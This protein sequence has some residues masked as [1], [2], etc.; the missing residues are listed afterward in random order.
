MANPTITSATLT[1]NFIDVVFSEAVYTSTGASGALTTADFTLTYTDNADTGSSAASLAAVTKTTNAALSG[2]ETSIRMHITTTG[3]PMGLA[4]IEVKPASSTAIYNATDE[5]MAD[6]ETTGVKTLNSFLH[7]YVCKGGASGNSGLIASLPKLTLVQGYGITATGQNKILVCNGIFEE[8]PIMDTA[9]KIVSIVADINNLWSPSQTAIDMNNTAISYCPNTAVTGKKIAMDSN[10]VI[11]TAYND[12]GKS[13]AVNKSTDYGMSWINIKAPTGL[14][15]SSSDL[16][17]QPSI[18][19]D[20]SDNLHMVWH[21]NTVAKMFYAKYTSSTNTWSAV[22]QIASANTSNTQYTPDIALDSSGYPHIVWSGYDT[23]YTTKYQIKYTKWTGSAWTNWVN[24][25][26]V[27]GYDQT[28]P[29]IVIGANNYPLVTWKGTDATYTTITQIKYSYYNGT[30]WSAAAN[31]AAAATYNQQRP[32]I[33]Y[34]ASKVYLCWNAM[35]ATQTT[36]DQA[37]FCKSSDEGATWGSPVIIQA[38]AYNH[39]GVELAFATNNDIWCVSPN[40]NGTLVKTSTSTDDGTTWGAWTSTGTP[41]NGT[42]YHSNISVCSTFEAFIRPVFIILGDTAYMRLSG[43]WTQTVTGGAYILSSINAP[44]FGSVLL[45]E[46]IHHRM[47]IPSTGVN[48]G[49]VGKNTANNTITIKNSKINSLNTHRFCNAMTYVTTTVPITINFDNCTLYNNDASGAM[50]LCDSDTNYAQLN[51]TINDCDFSTYVVG[52]GFLTR[53]APPLTPTEG[54][55]NR[56]ITISGTTKIRH[57]DQLYSIMIPGHNNQLIVNDATFDILGSS[58]TAYGY[59]SAANNI[60]QGVYQGNSYIKDST[61]KENGSNI[62]ATRLYD[63]AIMYPWLRYPVANKSQYTMDTWYSMQT[64]GSLF[65]DNIN[66]NGLKHLYTP[67]NVCLEDNTETY[68]TNNLYLIRASVSSTIPGVFLIKLSVNSGTAY[69]I[70]Y[71]IYQSIQTTA[72]KSIVASIYRSQ[73]SYST[74]FQTATYLFNSNTKDTWYTKSLT[75]T[76]N[77]TED[78]YLVFTLPQALDTNNKTIKITVPRFS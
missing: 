47:N 55:S 33:Y 34:R 49:S 71:D 72:S 48:Y 51:I 73:D 65:F 25:A 19:I 37:V 28:E 66:S 41:P 61:I 69:T 7:I 36:T 40:G 50:V 21:S 17:Y 58:T 39:R 68:E 63:P 31:V 4:T 11:Y 53:S 12:N 6:T 78:Y 59:N 57:D 76:P 60:E 22:T 15:E 43:A 18:V 56:K 16:Q 10:K 35:N 8:Y 32:R 2:G 5:A 54:Y 74:T 30:T 42:T 14:S 64:V 24:I 77:S 26:V 13:V 46:N 1:H 44:A 52:D 75:F 29:A 38:E 27:S 3:I 45:T 23:T 62:T 67:L 20:S 70:N 9:G